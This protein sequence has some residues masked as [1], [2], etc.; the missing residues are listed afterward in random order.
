VP[1]AESVSSSLVLDAS[2]WS[3]A[4]PHGGYVASQL[5][6]ATTGLTSHPVRSLYVQFLAPAVEGP[7]EVDA[8]LVREGR[9]AA[10][11]T[12][13]MSSGGVTAARACVV[14]GAARPGPHVNGPRPPGIQPPEDVPTLELPPSFVPFAQYLEYRPAPERPPFQGGPADLF[15]WVRYRDDRP[16]DETAA[17]VLVD[18]L[19]PGLYGALTAPAPIP[20]ADLY[21]QFFGCQPVTGWTLGRMTTRSAGDGWCVDDSEV[22]SRDGQL[23][24]SARQ[25]RLVLGEAA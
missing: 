5:L 20:S 4:G 3:F 13:S 14:F 21:V 10:F 15:G 22:W 2:W 17:T 25:T 6:A 8:Q 9:S 23:L 18:A 16:V 19:P 24:A 7:A 11:A 12:A 1:V